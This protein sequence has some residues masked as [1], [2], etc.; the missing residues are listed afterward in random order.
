[1]SNN[2]YKNTTVAIAVGGNVDSG[3]C[4][5]AGTSVMLYSGKFKNVENLKNGD[6]LMGDDSKPR[7]IIE[8][9]TGESEMFEISPSNGKSCKVNGEHILCLKYFDANKNILHDKEKNTFVVNWVELINTIP[10]TKSKLFDSLD[11]A[12]SFFN[13][14]NGVKLEN[15]QIIELS[16]NN[17]NK[18]EKELQ[19]KLKWYRTEVD[20]NMYENSTLAIDPYIVGIWLGYS[21]STKLDLSS[22]NK[23]MVRTFLNCKLKNENYETTNNSNIFIKFLKE[24]DLINNKSIPDVFKFSSKENRLK[25]LAGLIDS[26]GHYDNSTNSYKFEISKIYK[27]MIVDLVFLIKSLGFV[28]SNVKFTSDEK[29]IMF[30]FC[31]KNQ[32]NIPCLLEKNI[33]TP[34]N[35]YCLNQNMFDFKVKSIGINKYYGFQITDNGRFLLN[36]FSVV[37]NSSLVGVLSS[38]TPLL[39]DGN[40]SA[41]KLVAKHPHE[42]ASGRTSDISTRIVEIPNSN[43]A[44]TLIDLCGHEAYLKTTTFG[45]SGHFP[46]YGFLIVSASRGIQQMTKQHMRLFMSLSVPF[47]IIITHADLAVEGDYINTLE[48]ITKTCT[49]MSNR[50]ITNVF[51]N[52]LEHMELCTKESLNHDI[53]NHNNLPLSEEEF[54]LKSDAINTIVEALSNINDGKQSIVPVLTMSNKTGFFLDVVKAILG[55]LKPKNFWYQGNESEIINNKVVKH[56]KLALEKQQEGLSSIL[57]SAPSLFKQKDFLFYVDSAYNV[58]GIG[59]VITGINRGAPIIPGPQSFAYLGPFGKEFKKIRIKS[60]HNNMREEIP[61]LQNH[62]RGCV[63]FALT[64]RSELKREQIK[65]GIVMLSSLEMTKNI[66]YRFK[67]VITMYT[68]ADKSITL[69]TGYSPVIHLNTIRQSARIIIDPREN[70]NQDV[71]KFEGKNSTV[72]VATFKF[73][74]HPEYL[75]L[76]NKFLLRSGTIQGIG[77]IIGLTSVEDDMDA[78]PDQ[79]K[80]GRSRRKIA[81]QKQNIQQNTQV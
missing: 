72:V 12:Q 58:H 45:V 64:D 65:K 9:H 13:S 49:L 52:N 3:K 44:I 35:D 75:E 73:K 41:R 40:G 18:L 7:T 33:S 29:T 37:H 11:L 34:L 19:N 70:N 32:E 5:I 6:I 76:Y 30:N 16:V 21:T 56:F 23:K 61:S 60:N 4:F 53:N 80:G 48:A 66:C 25:L 78:K 62:H 51:V 14:L 8:T 10:K 38:P 24:N 54:K 17:F 63:N 28:T 55:Q 81:Q 15:N 20:F 27:N 57:P 77:L 67:A 43:E 50:Q 42:I 36:D 47:L 46:D 74:Q 26:D 69:K 22:I 31:G 1:M 39:D 59:L 79:I 2:T 68:R 71:I